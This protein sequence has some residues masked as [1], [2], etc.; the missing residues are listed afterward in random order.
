MKICD[1][2][3]ALYIWILAYLVIVT[4]WISKH[5]DLIVTVFVGH[6]HHVFCSNCLKHFFI[7]GIKALQT[8][9]WKMLSMES[10]WKHIYELTLAGFLKLVWRPKLLKKLFRPIKS[11]S[12]SVWMAYKGQSS[13]G[14]I[15]ILY[16]YQLCKTLFRPIN[17]INSSVWMAYKGQSS[18]RKPALVYPI[19]SVCISNL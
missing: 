19:H 13:F 17:S 1:L 10:W 3:L 4:L 15:A 2:S 5:R 6:E 16:T 8:E 14:I 7:H 9:G 11:T 12:P 18:F